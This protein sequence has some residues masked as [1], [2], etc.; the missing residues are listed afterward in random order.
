MLEIG[1]RPI[2][3]FLVQSRSSSDR[4]ITDCYYFSKYTDTK[5]SVYLPLHMFS[6]HVYFTTEKP[7]RTV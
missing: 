1:K 4:S 2:H 3:R 6:K 5:L 7:K